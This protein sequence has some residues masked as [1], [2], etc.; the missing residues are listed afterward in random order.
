MAPL[1]ILSGHWSNTGG[2]ILSA[3]VKGGFLKDWK[4]K[5]IY[6]REKNIAK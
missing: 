4:V 6:L 2:T 5:I 1:K 3:G